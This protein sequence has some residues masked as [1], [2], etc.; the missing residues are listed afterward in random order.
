MTEHIMQYRNVFSPGRKINNHIIQVNI[1]IWK[2]TQ[3][4]R[5]YRF[6]DCLK[7]HETPLFQLKSSSQSFWK[8][9]LKWAWW[10]WE[11]GRVVGVVRQGRGE[12][13]GGGKL[14]SPVAHAYRLSLKISGKTWGN[15]TILK[16]KLEKFKSNEIHWHFIF[17]FSRVTECPATYIL[18]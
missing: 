11:E 18:Q 14:S 17:V 6:L 4:H 2:V 15:T 9:Q 7:G 5:Y 8:M 13:R 1:T 10:L 12:E 16:K 3:N